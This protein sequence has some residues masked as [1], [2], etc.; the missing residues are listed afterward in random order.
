MRGRIGSSFLWR[1]LAIA[2]LSVVPE[3]RADIFCQP[4]SGPIQNEWREAGA[5]FLDGIA[6]KSLGWPGSKVG[7]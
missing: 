1:Y 4:P 6:Q 7:I 5:A 2:L 3:A